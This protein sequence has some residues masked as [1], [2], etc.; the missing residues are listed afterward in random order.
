MLDILRD[1]LWQFIGVVIA[2]IAI[3]IPFAEKLSKK[4]K[5]TQSITKKQANSNR[6]ENMAQSPNPPPNS[7]RDITR[8]V[9]EIEDVARQL[10]TGEFSGT[11]FYRNDL[12]TYISLALRW[13]V[14][15]QHHEL[16]K[17]L[18]NELRGYVDPKNMP[19]YRLTD[20]IVSHENID[21]FATQKNLFQDSRQLS[22]GEFANIAIK[23]FS[24]AKYCKYKIR[25]GL[26][27]IYNSFM[28][29]HDYTQ[30][31]D[32]FFG[33]NRIPEYDVNSF[34]LCKKINYADVVED[35]NEINMEVFLYFDAG[36]YKK[37]R[38]GFKSRLIAYLQEL[39]VDIK[40]GK[41]SLQN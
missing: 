14:D 11:E 23:N 30:P 12:K 21:R 31:Y 35:G 33:N 16:W 24:Q 17:F 9:E 38:I 39:I 2:V 6:P 34:I 8:V 4:G 37:I 32:P 36:C 1:P 25:T 40:S 27:E 22:F 20:A 28:V 41:F 29:N 3:L 18:D 10:V 15:L 5:Q 13:S 19:A 7:S 26:R